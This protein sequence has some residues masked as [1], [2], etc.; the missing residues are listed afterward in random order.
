MSKFQDALA[1]SQGVKMYID[2]HSYSQLWMTRMS[3]SPFSNCA[4]C[5]L[6]SGT[7]LGG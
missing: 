2:I 7:W 5:E 6:G 1:Y 3:P 4:R